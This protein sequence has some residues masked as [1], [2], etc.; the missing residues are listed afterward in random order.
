M[1]VFLPVGCYWYLT[2]LQSG[3][4]YES[5]FSLM[6]HMLMHAFEKMWPNQLIDHL[7][8]VD[9]RVNFVLN[10]SDTFTPMHAWN[11][12]NQVDNDL[13]KRNSTS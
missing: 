3:V 7:L 4:L 13:I 10:L 8:Q 6:K 11:V 5:F 12:K 2:V 9:H 1:F